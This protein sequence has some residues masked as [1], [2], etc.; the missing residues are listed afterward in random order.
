MWDDAVWPTVC[1]VTP[2]SGPKLSTI[3]N[4][5]RYEQWSGKVPPAPGPL[6]E[7]PLAGPER[8]IQSNRPSGINEPG[9]CFYLNELVR[10][11]PG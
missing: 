6:G 3:A 11:V 8:R 5:H 4:S 7:H 1:V 2:Q 10:G 9:L